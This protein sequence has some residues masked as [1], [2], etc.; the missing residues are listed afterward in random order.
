M[1]VLDAYKSKW[2]ARS[3]MQAATGRNSCQQQQRRNSQLLPAETQQWTAIASYVVQLLFFLAYYTSRQ[4]P[5]SGEE[6]SIAALV[7]LFEH[8]GSVFLFFSRRKA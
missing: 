3:S 1:T 4:C 8:C 2:D 7:F 6:Q 5:H